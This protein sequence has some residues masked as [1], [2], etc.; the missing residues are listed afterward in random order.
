MTPQDKDET[1]RA[2]RKKIVNQKHELRRLSRQLALIHKGYSGRGFAEYVLRRRK[3]MV[4][5]F[6]E[7]AV[8]PIW[9]KSE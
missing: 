6:G 7:A 9:G 5:A 8:M 1:I 3:E 4:E 2:L